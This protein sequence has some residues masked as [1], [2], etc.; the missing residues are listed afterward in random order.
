[1]GGFEC[2]G[3]LRADHLADIAAELADL[4]HQRAANALQACVGQHEYGFNF[5]PQLAVHRGHLG[6]V[7]EVGEVA[8]AAHDGGGF[9]RRAEIDDEPVEGQHAYAPHR[10]RGF[11]NLINALRKTEHGFFVMRGSHG[12]DDLVEQAIG[13]AYH[14]CMA[15][16]ERVKGAGIDGSARRGRIGGRH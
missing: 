8:N 3:N 13:A 6:F 2:G 15:E 7:V 9:V 14:V 1:M 12:N 4:A 10:Y 16:C 5:G 11:A